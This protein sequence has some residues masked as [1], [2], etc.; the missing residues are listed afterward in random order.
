VEIRMESHKEKITLLES[1]IHTMQN[2][3][4]TA[5]NKVTLIEYYLW[6]KTSK[7]SGV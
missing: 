5:E 3:K 6:K 1:I 4:L 7:I 2:N